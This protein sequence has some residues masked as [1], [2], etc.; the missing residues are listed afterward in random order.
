MKKI[1]SLVLAVAICIALVVCS[2][3]IPSKHTGN[4]AQGQSTNSHS[5]S[6]APKK[7][8]NSNVEAQYAEKALR[9]LLEDKD[10]DSALDMHLPA[11]QFDLLEIYVDI[12]EDYN[13]NG[14]YKFVSCK[15][16]KSATV[17]KGDTYDSINDILSYYGHK[18]YSTMI[19]CDFSV[20]F[21]SQGKNF[22]ET[23]PVYMIEDGNGYKILQI[24]ID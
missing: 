4:S 14:D 24:V 17:S 21:I 9:R 6:A 10:P 23:I 2:S 18:T 3:S 8:N 15:Y 19:K 13:L 1:I 16:L 5:N 7:E 12:L 22:T 11:V 20:T